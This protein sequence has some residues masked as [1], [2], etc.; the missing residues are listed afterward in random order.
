MTE[1]ERRELDGLALMLDQARRARAEGL[2]SNWSEALLTLA[3]LSQEHMDALEGKRFLGYTGREYTKPTHSELTLRE[4]LGTFRE[5]RSTLTDARR[6]LRVSASE[7]R[8]AHKLLPQGTPSELTPTDLERAALS[9]AY[10][11]L[12]SAPRPEHPDTARGYSI[13]LNHLERTATR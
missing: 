2:S 13:A 7:D 11:V 4:A 6:Q 3:R 8:N 12:V 1:Q 10:V 9:Y 5:R